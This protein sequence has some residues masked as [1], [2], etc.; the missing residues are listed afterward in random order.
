MGKGIQAPGARTERSQGVW[1]LEVRGRVSD[2]G[3]EADR[4]QTVQ[5]PVGLIKGFDF[6]FKC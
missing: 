3:C 5:D 1:C 6:D 2:K 4:G